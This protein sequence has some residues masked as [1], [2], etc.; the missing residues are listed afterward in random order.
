MSELKPI[1]TPYNF[2]HTDIFLGCYFT[3]YLIDHYQE[4]LN[5]DLSKLAEEIDNLRISDNEAFI[6]RRLFMQLRE[7]FHV[8]VS[9]SSAQIEGNNTSLMD[10]AKTK[11]EINYY[12]PQHI[13]E[14]QNIERAIAFIDNQMHNGDINKQFICKLHSII[15]D[16]LQTP[17]NGK[18]D[19]TPGAY[20]TSNPIFE[21]HLHLPPHWE[22]VED[23]MDKLITFI[24]EPNEP[25]YDLLKATV[26]QHRMMW[27]H[28]FD[29][30]NGRL[31][32]LLSYAMIIK[33]GKADKTVIRRNPA[34]ILCKN[35]YYTHLAEA[36][37]LSEKGINS[38]IEFIFSSI[39]EEISKLNTLTSYDFLK[40]NVLIPAIKRSLD[41][42]LINEQEA[43]VL[44]KAAEKQVIQAS[45]VKEIYPDKADAEV[46]REIKRMIDKNILVQEAI[47]TRKYVMRIDKNFL[48]SEI[49]NIVDE[50]G[51]LEI[52]KQN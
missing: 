23:Y 3:D 36:D 25:K 17:P 41:K 32:R 11:W 42:K 52:L 5:E 26:T 37:K 8:V 4:Y 9:V 30:A 1:S 44:Y 47:G 45:D 27:I 2:K 33:A 10:Y 18:G 22:Q 51:F 6:N 43:M 16:G 7:V 19:K 50:L 15:V 48:L 35:G 21:N 13:K 31:S 28:P 34:L 24:N 49:F 12:V 38:W 39:K 46:S 14:I 40:T 20:R 29:N